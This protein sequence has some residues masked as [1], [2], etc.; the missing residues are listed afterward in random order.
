[1]INFG[2]LHEPAYA[3]S[4]RAPTDVCLWHKADIA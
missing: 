1:M 2:A 3:L 4:G